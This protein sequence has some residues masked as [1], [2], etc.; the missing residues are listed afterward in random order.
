VDRAGLADAAVATGAV[1][2]PVK[3]PA[4]EAGTAEQPGPNG[5]DAVPALLL[6]AAGAE[7]LGVEL[8]AGPDPL[9]PQAAAPTAMLAAAAAVSIILYFTVTPWLW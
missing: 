1:D 3:L 7:V 5:A 8:A 4:P 2:I 9:E 6:A